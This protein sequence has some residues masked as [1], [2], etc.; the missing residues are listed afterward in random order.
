MQLLE[1]LTV[2]FA[3]SQEIPSIYGTPNFLT[4]STS[5]RQL[6]LSWANSIQ[7]SR[8]LLTSWRYILILSSYQRLGL[9]NGLFPSGFPTITLCKPLSCPYAPH[10]LPISFVSHLPPA[11]YWVRST[12]HSAPRY[13]AFSIP[14]S[15]RP[16]YVDN[17][18]NVFM[19]ITVITI[20]KDFFC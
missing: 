9:S 3:A 5:A 17:L 13:A 15:S 11:Q 14:P 7:S 2:N 8:P 12:D 1:K 19:A 20:I 18:T 6:S 10:T 4:V 16:S